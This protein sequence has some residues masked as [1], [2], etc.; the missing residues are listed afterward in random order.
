MRALLL[1][2]AA[3]AAALLVAGTLALPRLPYLGFALRGDQVAVIDA[4]SAAA[5]AG[6]RAGDAVRQVWV[7]E[8]GA[9]VPGADPTRDTPARDIPARRS[10]A[11]Q[12]RSLRRGTNVGLI[13][14]AP[15][16]PARSVFFRLEAPPRPE[17]VRRLLTLLTAATFLAVGVLTFR[18]R[19]DGLG[20]SFLVF[21]VAMSLVFGQ[22]ASPVAAAR[23]AWQGVI[24]DLSGLLLAV[25]LVQ[26]V[27]H[28]P[29]PAAEPTRRRTLLWTGGAALILGMTSLLGTIG[30]PLPP[31]FVRTAAALAALFVAGCLALALVVFLGSFR[32]A[33]TPAD[34]L[35]LR[36]VQWGTLLALAP[37][38]PVVLV[39]NLAPEGRG[40]PGDQYAVLAVILLPISYMYAIIRH[41]I[42]DVRIIVRRGVI[43]FLSTAALALVYFSLITF[44]GPVLDP[45]E[46]HPGVAFLSLGLIALTFTS[47]RSLI[48]RAVDRTFFAGDSDRRRRLSDLSGRVAT[49]LDSERLCVTLYRDLAEGMNVELAALYRANDSGRRFELRAWRNGTGLDTDAPSLPGGTGPPGSFTLNGPLRDIVEEIRG[50]ILADDLLRD[51]PDAARPALAERIGRLGFDLFVPL[52]DG[53][54]LHAVV[55]LKAAA[56]GPDS[57]DL[58]LLAR[59]TE[60]ASLALTQARHREDEIERERLAG[61]LNVA[62]RIQEHLLP[63]EPPLHPLLD[64]AGSTH[65]CD[66]VGGDSHDYAQL[67]DGRIGIA[68]GD[69]SGKGVPAAILM[70]SLQASF[71]AE[72]ETGRTPGPLLAALNRRL[73]DIAEPERFVCYCYALLDP[74]RFEL[75]YANAGLEPPLLVRADGTVADLTEGGTVLGVVAGAEYEE[76]CL[77]VLPGD[78]LVL[79]SDGLTDGR[80]PDEIPL[81]RGRIPELV[82]ARPQASAETLRVTLLEAAG[83]DPAGA[84]PSPPDDVTLVVV[85]IY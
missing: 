34:A 3:L 85:R 48:Q 19:P 49:M 2:F 69:V 79:F 50:P 37:L 41:Q 61:E 72:A 51:A 80:T 22:A 44:L 60:D 1:A 15:A 10:D 52:R 77:H 62:R 17:T 47:T 83:L 59:I 63:A 28:F 78:V 20:R 64:I 25:G 75:R 29:R 81:D 23:P 36:V 38:L 40:L 9:A 66:Q 46:G 74:A 18:Q 31:L 45:R 70:A 71:R 58:A 32:R 57:A 39:R 11:A 55:A 14:A 12:L 6:L 67:P 68:V 35:R 82:L 53:P 54:R 16:A 5:R 27:L 7:Q 21:C 8:G 13:V 73:L 4:G 33:V 30:P 26:F 43:Y 42:F 24:D 76:G 84:G 56:H 65:P